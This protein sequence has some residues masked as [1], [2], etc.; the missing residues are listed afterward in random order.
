MNIVAMGSL[1]QSWL[2]PEYIKLFSK[3]FYIAHVYGVVRVLLEKYQ[4]VNYGNR[5][6]TSFSQSLEDNDTISNN[7]QHV[8]FE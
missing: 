6:K 5:R 7:S 2:P 8:I 4:W 3:K 1:C